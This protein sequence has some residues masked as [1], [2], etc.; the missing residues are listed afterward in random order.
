MT[1]R[2]KIGLTIL[3]TGLFT[4]LG[5]LVVVPSMTTCSPCKTVF[6]KTSMVS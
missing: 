5:V 3:L 1:V 4:V 2:F 6:R